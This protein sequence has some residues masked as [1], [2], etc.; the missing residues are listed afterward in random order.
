MIERESLRL[1]RGYLRRDRGSVTLGQFNPNEEF[2]LANSLITS[3]VL[4]ASAT[5]FL[6][7]L[8]LKM[9]TGQSVPIALSVDATP[10]ALVD[11]LDVDEQIVFTGETP[12]VVSL[13]PG[14]Y[15]FLFTYGSRAVTKSVP[16]GPDFPDKLRHEF[17][18]SE[19]IAALIGR[20]LTDREP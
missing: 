8:G 2:Q 9:L 19:D 16:V 17:W 18:D 1:V 15:S 13:P 7:G 20:F 4:L 14:D 5:I 3:L 10:F 6:A 11:V 12:F